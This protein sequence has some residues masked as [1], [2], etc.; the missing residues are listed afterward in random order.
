[1]TEK[2]NKGHL[3]FGALPLPHEKLRS[4]LPSRR[5]A[6]VDVDLG[7]KMRA[8][9]DDLVNQPIPERFVELLK[10]LDQARENKPQ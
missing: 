5:Q 8:M 9:Y 6:S 2:K 4:H 7:K 10:Q 3:G 1:M